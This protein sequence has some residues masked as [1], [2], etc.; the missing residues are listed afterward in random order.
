MALLIKKLSY[1]NFKKQ[2]E[3]LLKI[4]WDIAEDKQ[5]KKKFYIK[6]SVFK[7]I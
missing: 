2:M 7:I 3:K 4:P 1:K 5:I 6:N